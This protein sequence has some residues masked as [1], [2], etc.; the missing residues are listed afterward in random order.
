MRSGFILLFEYLVI[1][2]PSNVI[3]PEVGSY[4][5]RIVRPTVD[6]PHPDSPTK[7]SVSPGLIEKLTPLTALLSPLTREKIPC[8]ASGKYL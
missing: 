7:P 8:E 3:D 5:L 6:L 4:N 2:W 1:S